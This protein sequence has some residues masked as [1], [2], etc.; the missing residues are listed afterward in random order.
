MNY[1]DRRLPGKTLW[2]YAYEIVPP[3]DEDQISAIQTLLANEHADAIRSARTWTGTLVCDP[4]VTQILVVSDS[5]NQTRDVN[6]R[7]ESQ[8]RSGHATFRVTPCMVVTGF[9]GEGQPTNGGGSPHPR[10]I[11]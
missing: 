9:E 5:P 7:I 3:Q 11:D 10:S 4:L 1:T 6:R 8:L 2:A